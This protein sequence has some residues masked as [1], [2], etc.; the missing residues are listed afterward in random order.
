MKRLLL[1]PFLVALTACGERT[2]VQANIAE[3][4]VK[5]VKYIETEFANHQQTRQ[6]GGE[7][8]SATTSPLSFKVGGTIEVLHVKKGQ[9]VEKG[10]IIAELDKEEFA[11]ALAKAR[12]SLGSATAAHVQAKDQY[13]RANK[14]K[15]KGFVSDSE[16]FSIKADLDAKAQQV[17]VA[18]TD[19]NNAELSL[20]RTALYAPFSGQVSAVFLDEFT[21]IN[22]GTTVIELINSNA[23]QVDFLVP[24]S[25]IGEV[26]F[27]EQI[28]VIIPALNG[29]VLESSVSEIGAVVE[30]GNAYSVTLM[31]S[32][33]ND[34]LRNGMTAHVV[35]NIGQQNEQI[36]F[37]PL[38]AFDFNDYEERG[39][40]NNAAIFIVNEQLTLEKRYVQVRRN[41]NSDV[42]VLNNL[43]AGEKVVVAGVPYLF[44]GQQVSLWNGI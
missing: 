4:Q 27:G 17:N 33:T 36:V 30:K 44:E 5:S 12:A 26:D 42:V 20:A 9:R 3:K 19:V 18:I 38:T 29:L 37:L 1:L 22:S 28:N 21:K 40:Q 31:L 2:E 43:S 6:F 8:K 32:Q 11:L 16:L 25:L 7:V 23:Y 35:F 13:E 24:E 15:E 39:E 41:I 10:D 34:L 14:L